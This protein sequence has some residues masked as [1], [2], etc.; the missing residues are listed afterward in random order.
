MATGNLAT[1]GSPLTKAAQQH[2]AAPA[3]LALA[4]LLKRSPVMLVI[5]STSSAEHLAENVKAA[6]IQLRD[7]AFEAIA[8][9]SV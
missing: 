3:Q 4:W 6:Q 9:S 7:D 2:N 8:R 5:P 1:E